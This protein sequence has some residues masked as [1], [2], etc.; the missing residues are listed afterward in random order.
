[1]RA[2]AAFAIAGFAFAIDRI[3][4]SVAL[5]N[6][7]SFGIAGLIEPISHRNAGL[8]ANIPVPR[9]LIILGTTLIIAWIFRR[10]VKRLPDPNAR[11][12]Y[13]LA[14]LVG[15][16]LGNLWDRV[17][18]GFVFDWILL[19]GRSAINAADVAIAIG[20]GWFLLQQRKEK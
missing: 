19:F 11:D 15:G 4:K 3:T 17:V 1:M 20:I 9:I 8:I 7:P 5:S 14:L 6:S 2:L 12:I 18:Y 10:I 13:P 16:A